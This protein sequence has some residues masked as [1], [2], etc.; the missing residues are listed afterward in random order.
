M[1]PKKP[2]PYIVQL[3]KQMLKRWLE[4][5]AVGAM[6]FNGWMMYTKAWD[7]TVGATMIGAIGTFYATMLSA[8][9]NIKTDA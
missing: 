2:Q 3:A 8:K 1:P 9:K 7:G 4:M 5:L 6:V